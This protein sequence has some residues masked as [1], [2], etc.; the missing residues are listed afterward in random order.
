[1]FAYLRER[2]VAPASVSEV[3]QSVIV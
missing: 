2:H 3:M 1:V